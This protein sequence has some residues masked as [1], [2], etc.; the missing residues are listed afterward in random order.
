MPL[1]LLNGC[2]EKTFLRLCD[3]A[4]NHDARV[5][6]KVRVADVLPLNGSGVDS[7]LYGYGLKSHFD[8]VVS[9]ATYQPLFCVE[10]DGPF[11]SGDTATISRD[12]KKNSLCD[13]FDMP[14]LRINSRYIDREYRGMDLLTYFANVWFLAK[15]FFEAQEQGHVPYDEP[16]DPCMIAY[17]GKQKRR[18]P[19]WLSVQE[20]IY[21]QNLEKAGR[22]THPAVSDWVGVDGDG[23]YRCLAWIQVADDQYLT[24][25]TGMRSQQFP[26]IDGEILQQIAT[27]DIRREV[28][29]YLAEGPISA[30]RGETL[31]ET[32]RKYQATYEMRMSCTVGS[33]FNPLASGSEISVS[34]SSAD[35]GQQP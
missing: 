21:I 13:R 6:A 26:V 9:D 25:Q 29:R 17:D 30:V 4:G 5:F 34:V 32:I 1:R 16:F 7:D 11:H 27:F 14:L 3:V 35:P 33:L 19:Y 20:Q 15:G 22:I 23:N 31:K 8:F 24:V 10:F 18:W 28:D 12:R 2:E